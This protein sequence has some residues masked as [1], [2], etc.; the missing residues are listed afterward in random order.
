MAT[1]TATHDEPFSDELEGWLE[2]DGEKTLGG[3]E[4]VFDERTFAVTVLLLMA[5]TALPIPTGGL[6]H[7]FELATVVV[8]I[9]MVAGRRT[10]WLPDRWRN[11]TLGPLATE[12]AM[13]T[14]IR[15][16]RWCERF[17]RP[18]GA[19][20]LDRTPALRVLGLLI[21]ALTVAAA[22]APPFSMLDT[23]PALGVVLIAMAMLLGDLVLVAAGL[24][25]GAVGTGLIV[26]VGAAVARFM[27]DLL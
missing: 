6:T 17:S 1:A 13:P 10:V 15:V 26:V 24:A 9:E 7:V 12:R 3:L 18:R 25:V 5:P 2:G 23:L 8:A 11:R 4:E 20:L 21:A 16:V 22:L 19:A 14:L 27:R